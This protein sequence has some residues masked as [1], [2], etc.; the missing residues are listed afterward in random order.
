MSVCDM[1]GPLSDMPVGATIPNPPP[2][3]HNAVTPGERRNRTPIY[4]TGVSDTR[5]FLAWLRSRCPKGILAQMKGER[6]MV[7][8]G[9]ADDFRA[10]ITALRS[11]DVSKGVSFHTFSLPEDRCLRLLIKNLGRGMPETVMREKLEALGICV[12]GVLELRSG[13]RDQDPEKDRPTTP[14]FIVTM[15]R[16]PDVSKVR[17]ITQL[18]GLRTTVESYTAPRGPLQCRRCQCFGHPAWLRLRN[19]VRR[20]WRGPPVRRVLDIQKTA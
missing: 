6:H 9:T 10:A 7:V 3:N 11:L 14:H 8:P 5:G 18:C 4:I 20:V 15:A 19:S 1:P 17:A 12:Q 2:A 13:R 16:G